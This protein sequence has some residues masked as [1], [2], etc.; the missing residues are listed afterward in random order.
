[1]ATSGG[2]FSS[3]RGGVDVESTTLKAATPAL[4]KTD[5]F[6][7]G[8]PR[9]TYV[10]IICSLL[11]AV[12][13]ADWQIMSVILQPLKTE[14][15]LTD[16]QVGL[17]G[18][19]YFIGIILC[20]LP[21]SRLVDTWSRKKT[22][23]LMA[24]VWSIFTLLTGFSGGLLALVIARLGVGVG[25][26]GFAPGGTALVSASYPQDKRGQKLGIFNTFITVGIIIGAIVGG[27][28]SAH[29]GGWRTPFFVFSVPG[30]VLGI[31]AF[32]MQDYRLK[33]ADG[34]D[35][36]HDS[37]W[38]NLKE[39][40][41]IPTLRWLYVGLG[42]YAVL[43]LSVGT[44]FPAL[45]MRAY[46]IKEDTAGLVMGLVTIIGLA[47]PILGGILADRWQKK[48][49]G[50]RMQLAGTS[51]AIATVFLLL[52][53]LAALDIHNRTLMFF[54]ALMM[55]LHSISVGMALPAVAATTQDVVPAHLKGLSWGGA[56]LALYVLGGAWGPFLVGLIS[57]AS[58][59]GYQGL[60]L[61]MGIAGLFGFI[62]SRLWFVTARHVDHDTQRARQVT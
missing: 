22:I 57:D 33:Q 16:S 59:G 38:N 62:A 31:L 52:V 42:M 9:A 36:V 12:R 40:W 6:E 11:Y 37:L 32:F 41:R 15:G 24:F 1:V 5:R 14:L 20:T 25:E 54:C 18:T 26:A 45:L 21:T 4:Q 49:P 23:G 8:G 35:F 48:H 53:L 30:I 46:P 55:P 43:Q 61:G 47:G 56:M 17:A 13:Y 2:L 34:S 60:S 7:V 19:A 3:Q 27:Y 29:A 58:G 39:L 44:W 28:L 51:I 50:G 10:L